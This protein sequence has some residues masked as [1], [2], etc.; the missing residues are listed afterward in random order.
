MA[1][2]SHA[3]HLSASVSF[4]RW[5]L[6]VPIWYPHRQSQSESARTRL[7]QADKMSL[8]EMHLLVEKVPVG[9]TTCVHPH[10]PAHGIGQPLM[11][12]FTPAWTA[13]SA[14]TT[15]QHAPPDI[16][17]RVTGLHIVAIYPYRC[18]DNKVS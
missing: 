14:H 16:R 15:L 2:P 10:T 9:G 1:K 3:V 11:A 13:C 5:P 6:A 17:K 12:G 7:R 8:T 18:L 4:G